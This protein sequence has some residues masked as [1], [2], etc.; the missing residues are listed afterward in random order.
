M[1]TIA[2]TL[3][4]ALLLTA[5]IL[6]TTANAAAINRPDE[7]TV[8]NH[9]TASNPAFRVAVYPAAA[10]MLLRVAVEKQ[11]DQPLTIRLRDA[12]GKMLEEQYLGRKQGNFQYRFNLSDLAD[13]T[14]SV[15][16]SNGTEKS[17]HPI[18][19]TTPNRT[20]AVQ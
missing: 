2:Q 16:V 14:Y 3:L 10:P 1:K 7:P 18:T 9:F 8:V 4:A 11:T 13:G 15:E 17:V 6:A 12:S 20:V 5:P 19:L